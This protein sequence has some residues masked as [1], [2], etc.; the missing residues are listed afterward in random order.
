MS[1]ARQNLSCC[2]PLQEQ[3]QQRG[4]VSDEAAGSEGRREFRVYIAAE[5][6]LLLEA[7]SRLLTRPGTIEVT[8]QQSSFDVRA[9][10]ASEAEVLLLASRGSAHRDLATLHRVRAALP[11]VRILLIAMAEDE[12]AFLQFLDAGLSGYL[13]PDAS[14]AEVLAGVRAVHAGATVCPGALCSVLFRYFTQ[15]ATSS[16]HSRP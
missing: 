9:L 13:S 7:L 1:V 3:T 15:A 4:L 2:S 6:R 10:I 5:N 11:G 8:C 12:A 16:V 14:A